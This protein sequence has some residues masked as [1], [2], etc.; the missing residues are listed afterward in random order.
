[1]VDQYCQWVGIEGFV[2]VVVEYVD[3]VVVVV[4][5]YGW[6]LVD[7][8]V[9]QF[10]GFLQGVVVVVVQVEDDVIDFVFL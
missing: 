1:M 4:Y 6:V 10:G 2:F 7:E 9:G 5:Q 3:V 8:Q